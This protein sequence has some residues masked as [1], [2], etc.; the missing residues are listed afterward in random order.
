[1][2][3]VIGECVSSDPCDYCP[4]NNNEYCNGIPC[5]GKDNS[6]IIA[7]WLNSEVEE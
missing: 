7:E 1:M 3:K 6:E 2:A 4:H 5:S